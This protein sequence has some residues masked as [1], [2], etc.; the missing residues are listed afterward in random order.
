MARMLLRSGF[1]MATALLPIAQALG[2]AGPT[3]PPRLAE[4]ASVGLF[5]A[6]AA[7]VIYL[8]KRFKK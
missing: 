3:P 8:R 4:P 6:G 2:G 7:A 1:I 5:V